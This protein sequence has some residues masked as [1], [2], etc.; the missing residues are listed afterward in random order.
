MKILIDAH[1]LTGQ[2]AGKAFYTQNLLAGLSQLPEAKK[3]LFYLFSQTKFNPG[4]KV[5]SN[6]KW[7]VTNSSGIKFY[8]SL[9]KEIYCQKYDLFWSPTS[10]IPVALGR[11]KMIATVYDLVAFKK[12]KFKKNLKATLIEKL[13]LG[14]VVK[15]TTALITISQNTQNELVEMFPEAKAKSMVIP[16][17]PRIYSNP[18]LTQKVLKKYQLEDKKYLLF[19]GTLEPRKNL[20]NTLQAYKLFVDRLKS[21]KKKSPLFVLVGQKGWHSEEIFKTIKNL[22]LEKS[23]K[24]LGYIP[25]QDLP[26]LYNN[27]LFLVYAPFCEGFGLPVIEAIYFGKACLTSYASSLPEVVGPCGIKIDP[28]D[29][30]KLGK[31]MYQLW[32]DKKL[33]KK[34]EQATKVWLKNFSNIKNAK[35]LLEVFRFAESN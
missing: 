10:F 3:H 8:L 29:V 23:V 14:Q 9:L 31:S 18:T 27:C 21:E 13:L 26:D 11:G 7:R 28:N 12:T 20:P 15:K 2:K 32:N 1:G 35:K 6:F 24:T 22:K 30:Q 17:S 19:V 5:P 34:Y 25:D 16:G 4:F 33:R